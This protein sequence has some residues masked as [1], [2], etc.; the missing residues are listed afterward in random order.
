MPENSKINGGVWCILISAWAAIAATQ[1]IIFGYGMMMPGIMAEFGLDPATMGKIGGTGAWIGVITLFPASIIFSKLS[2]KISVPLVILGT[3]AG[4]FISG[5]ATG[6]PMLY[7][8]AILVA[9][10]SQLIATLLTGA[11]VRGV[12]LDAMTRV[13]GLENFIGPIGQII[14]TLV[15]AQL[16]TLVNGWRGVYTLMSII[17]LIALAVY[18]IV[19]GNGKRVNSGQAGFPG[20]AVKSAE[21]PAGSTL[22]AVKEAMSNKVVWLTGLAWPGTI[23]IWISM[24]YFYPTYAT[25]I[26]GLDLKTAGTIL[27]M[28][29]IFS[30]V[31]SLTSPMLA[32]KIGYDKP[33]ICIWGIL[34]PVFYYM[35]TVVHSVPLL[36]LFS[37]LAGYGCSCFVPLLFTNVYKAGLS[38]QAI[39]IA[40]GTIFVFIIMGTAIAGTAVGALTGILG[41][42]GALNIA[43]LTPLWFGAIT[44]FLP[45]LGYKKMAALK[46]A[47]E[48]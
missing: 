28:I 40:T 20:E 3:A 47:A 12:P 4:Q 23:I 30:A 9:V 14:A 45:E 15:M 41:I 48:K 44:L 38:R 18:F 34:L 37:A 26:L 21:V 29:P 24:F 16:L 2:P 31:A 19:W 32:K 25:T 17:M 5:R 1:I 33:L 7:I 42:K 6:I 35:M 43:C 13:N 46:A 8:G 11:K 36:C 10:F 22:S 27:A 39:T